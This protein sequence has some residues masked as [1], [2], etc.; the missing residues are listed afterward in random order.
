M[1]FLAQFEQWVG[2]PVEQVF[3][4]FANPRNLPRIMPPQSRTELVHLKLVPPPEIG[5]K[6]A[7]ITD[8]APLAGI[9]SEIVTTFRLLPFL[10]L[11]AQW[12]ALITEFEWNHH[13]A[14]VQ[15]IRTVQEFSPSS[16]TY[17]GNSESGEWYR[18]SRC[19]RIRPG[20]RL[21]R[22]TGAEVFCESPV[23]A[24][25]R[26]SSEGAEEA[27]GIVPARHTYRL[28]STTTAVP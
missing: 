26:I 25:F 22:K 7:T 17:S 19:D 16:R 27:A 28:G 24:N 6:F 3:L 13:F 2:A 12:I 15:K 4:F 21:V 5:D 11:R 9:G 18:H 8:Q 14:D 23:A 20:I 1:T 10:P